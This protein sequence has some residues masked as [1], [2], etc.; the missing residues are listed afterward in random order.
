MKEYS[1]RFAKKLRT[2]VSSRRG[3]VGCLV[4]LWALELFLVQ[5]ATLHELNYYA[6]YQPFLHRA[7]RA[8]L[9]LLTCTAL[10]LVLPRIFLAI[11]FAGGLL[12]SGVV[13]C[14]ESY[15]GHP[16]SA[17]MATSTAGEGVSVVSAGLAMLPNLFYLLIATFFV[18]IALLRILRK[19]PVGQLRQRLTRAG[20]VFV[21]YLLLIGSVNFYKPFTL[22]LGWES[23]GGIGSVYGYTPT[24]VAELIL[25]DHKEILARAIARTE[26][27]SDRLGG[28]L[29]ADFPYN[30]RLVFLQVESL[31]AAVSGFQVKGALV[32]P[33][34]DRLAKTSM[35]YKIRSEKMTGSCDADFTALTGTYP[36][37]DMPNYKI[38]N[39]PFFPSFVI[40]MAVFGYSTTSVHNVK[41][42]FF[43]RRVAY[44]KFKIDRPLFLEEL[45]EQE[46]LPF[47]HWAIL[48]HVMLNWA[49]D[50]I[51]ATSG[52]QFSL[53]ITATS[54]IPFR[55]T[56]SEARVLYPGNNDLAP[57]YLDSIH[58]VDQAIGEFVKRLPKGTVVIIYGDH[59]SGV[60][61]SDYDYKNQK[62]EGVG[63]VPFL[64]HQVGADLSSLQ[65]TRELPLAMSGELTLLDMMTYVHDVTRRHNQN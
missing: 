41:G 62:Y 9:N 34:L 42:A 65:R 46:N 52:K 60:N 12:F 1:I 40:E 13:L 51:A 38:P 7:V 47:D 6:G 17:T 58:Y 61:D 57:S 33:E 43:N 4:A 53:V 35:R 15:S 31:D 3:I 49:A 18:K 30:E 45:V 64:I 25:L 5:E 23:V 2:L 56:P 8:S 14:F 29:E 63:M 32:S 39:F 22:L 21:A 27:R 36:S 59:G 50:D 26:I 54:H 10:V 28:G 16:L 48:D 44:N 37:A 19:F 55:Y 20:Q 11:F 24:W